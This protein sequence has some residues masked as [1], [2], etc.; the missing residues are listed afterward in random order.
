M[1][2]SWTSRAVVTSE[3]ARHIVIDA[4]AP[5]DGFLLLA[6]TFYPGWTAQVDGTP[7]PVYRANISVRGIR[8]PK[9][10][11]EVRFTYEAPG[12]VH[13]LWLTLLALSTLIVWAGAA[14][15]VDR[16]VRR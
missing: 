12:F 13:G 1:A 3:D 10:K 7:T 16:R 8:L 6:D 2:S 4:E 15:Y 14:A 5:D 11:H 9:G